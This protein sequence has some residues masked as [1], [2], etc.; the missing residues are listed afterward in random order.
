MEPEISINEIQ[1]EKPELNTE[2]IYATRIVQSLSKVNL[3]VEC[4]QV[5]SIKMIERAF[6]E[7][8]DKINQSSV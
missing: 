3:K 1:K 2:F 7:Y 8:K 6:L 5:E 4:D